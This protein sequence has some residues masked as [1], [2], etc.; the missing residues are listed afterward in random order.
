MDWL[1]AGCG[2]G[3]P[4]RRKYRLARI[5]FDTLKSTIQ[6]AF[7]RAGMT[8]AD[9]E[10]CARVHAESTLDGVNSH[11]INRVARF[12]EFIHKG[13]INLGATPRLVKQFGSLEVYDGQRAP[14]VSNALWCTDRVSASAKEH[15]IAL[16]GL[17]NTNHWMRGGT[18]GWRAAEHGL[19][20][21]AW[22]N[23]ESSMPPWGGKQPRLGNNPFVM[24]IPRPHGP[25]VLD[26]AMSQYAYGK[27]QT[28]RL[29]GRQ[30]PFPGGYDTEGH[31]TSDP[32]SIEASQRILPMG[33]WKGSGFAVVLDVLAAVL[34][35]GLP[36]NAIDRLQ[37]GSCVA[38]SQVFIAI[39]PARLGGHDEV[40]RIASSVVEYTHSSA[41]DESGSTPEYPGEG[42]QR[43]RAR[44]LRDG[45]DV[46]DTVWREGQTIAG[47]PQPGAA[48]PST[49]RDDE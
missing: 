20:L 15:G 24:A 19:I 35:E 31:L 22:T 44:Q 5:S 36:T 32:A 49:A 43:R 46:D 6:Q 1:Y 26:M 48:D 45:I 29:Q 40:A 39:D 11:G 27:L 42:T 25:V 37:L 8:S 12:V 28:V 13:W 2:C 34:S 38:C 21:I 14:G 41:P 17:R 33:F 47:V 3:Q 16:L 30:L 4:P 23:T 10:T 18:Y 7:E 9:A